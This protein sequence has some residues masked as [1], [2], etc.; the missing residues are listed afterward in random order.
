MHKNIKYLVCPAWGWCTQ[1]VYML[2]KILRMP[3][4]D[5]FQMDIR[6]LITSV[7]IS[8]QAFWPTLFSDNSNSFWNTYQT[9]KKVC[10]PSEAFWVCT[11]LKRVSFV[12]NVYESQILL[13]MKRQF[14]SQKLP[15]KHFYLLRSVNRLDFQKIQWAKFSLDPL[16][17]WRELVIHISFTSTGLL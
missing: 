4:W 17:K 1:A 11:I 12:G 8:Q 9:Q 15:Y 2:G 13:Y 16:L 7:Q 10:L 14:T 3:H 6:K 5:L